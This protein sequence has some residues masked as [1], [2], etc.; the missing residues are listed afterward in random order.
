MTTSGALS[1]R[2]LLGA[3][4]LG[5]GAA[6]A[7]AA[8]FAPA[9]DPGSH[10]TTEVW[11][12]GKGPFRFVVDTGAERT[13]LAEDLADSLGLSRGRRVMVEGIV[14][15]VVAETAGVRELS[16]GSATRERLYLPLLPRSF[17]GADGYL[18]LDAIDGQRVV[19]DFRRR[20]VTVTS[21]RPPYVWEG[22]RPGETRIP[23]LG[24][25]GHLRAMDCRVDGVSAIVF[26][27]SGAEATSGNPPLLAALA[28]RNPSY[29]TTEPVILSG[30]TGGAMEGRLAR[31][32]RITLS[33]V[34]MTNCKLAIADLQVF[35]IWGL[36]GKPALM[37]GLNVLREFSAV[38]VDYGRME[39]RLDLASLML[40]RG[41]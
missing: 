4:C 16:A 3:A 5:L 18:G 20:L 2:S 39:Y 14:R 25:Y 9:L 1:R 28:E 17:L 15:S 19:F 32:K 12:D 22:R 30:I 37:I 6:S 8:A 13:V 33:D 41:A 11:L 21:P 10:L 36:A 35:N 29:L 24:G 26:I 34:V 27:D 7:R 23:A 31:V 38:S 40:A